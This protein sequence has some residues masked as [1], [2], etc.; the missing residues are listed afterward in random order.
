MNTTQLEGLI[1]MLFVLGILVLLVLP[2]VFG[3]VRD[4]RVDRQLREAEQGPAKERGPSRDQK[5][6]SRS[7][8]PSTA[9][10]YAEGR[11]SKKLVSS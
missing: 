9:T 6:S 10:W 5:S 11:R 3:I 4:R 8:V 2:A 1:G 7:T